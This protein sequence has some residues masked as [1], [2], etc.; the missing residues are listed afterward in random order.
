MERSVPHVPVISDV[1]KEM[2]VPLSPVVKA[3]G[4]VF[5]SGL[6]PL[7]LATGKLVRGDIQAQTRLSLENVKRALEAAGSS[8]EKVVKV[9]VFATNAGQ[10]NA[11]NEVYREFFPHNPPARTF[12]TVG[13]WP[14][15]FDIE[16]ECIALA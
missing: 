7:D 8:L 1:I 3:N 4:F 15:E 12:C 5:V 13:S 14:W 2:R 16:V 11:I 10:F 9:T 6:P